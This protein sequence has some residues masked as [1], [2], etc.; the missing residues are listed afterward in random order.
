MEETIA[1][2][3][4]KPRNPH[5]VTIS[6]ED[7]V[8]VEV[9]SYSDVYAIQPRYIVATS[10]GW[11]RV[12]ANANPFTGKTKR[13][14]KKRRNTDLDYNRRE[15]IQQECCDAINALQW[16]GLA[17]EIEDLPAPLAGLT[18]S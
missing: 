13:V 9:I 3:T 8:V 12:S 11:K 6:D 14:M 18:E 10:N 1:V 15:T 2:D 4:R 16:Y 17:W 5:R 7:P